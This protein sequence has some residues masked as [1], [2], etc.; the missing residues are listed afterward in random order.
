MEWPSSLEGN[1]AAFC[2]QST[3]EGGYCP[4]LILHTT[5]IGYSS[6]RKMRLG[7]AQLCQ[8]E[9]CRDAIGRLDGKPLQGTVQ[10][11]DAL[12]ECRDPMIR[13]RGGSDE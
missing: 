12:I 9:A 8:C 5:N 13:E 4:F 6:P 10:R 1:K 3:R 7:R 2:L 11:G